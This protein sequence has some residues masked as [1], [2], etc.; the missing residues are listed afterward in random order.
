MRDLLWDLRRLRRGRP[1]G[2][3]DAEEA[4]GGDGRL[5]PGA[6]PVGAVAASGP[7]PERSA[8]RG[9]LARR[10]VVIVWASIGLLVLGA[11]VLWALSR[12]SVVVVPLLVAMFPAAALTPLRNR[13]VRAGW[14]PFLAALTLLLALLAA[15]A[16]L[17]VGPIPA[18][19]AEM[20]ALLRSVSTAIGQLQAYL[21]RLP[22]GVRFGGVDQLVG[23]GTTLLLGADPLAGTVGVAITALTVL[24]GMALCVLSV[25]F[26]LY[27]GDR[28]GRA[29]A[30]LV[31]Q[32]HREDAL[33]L[34]RQ[35][36]LVVGAYVRAQLIIGLL[37]AVFIGIGLWLLGVPLVLPLALLIFVGAQ[38][39]IVGA[40]LAGTVSVLVALADGGLWLAVGALGVIVAVQFTEGHFLE[41]LLMSRLV[42][43]PAFG[44]I[45]SV[46]IGAAAIGVLGALLAVPV[47][48][49]AVRTVQFLRVRR[50]AG[51]APG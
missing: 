32:R 4:G 24:S 39:P 51:G 8:A 35:L 42:R 26:L 33:E 28:I 9:A 3:Q 2:S 47:T 19:V 30:A 31:P 18:I 13:M 17:I 43:L 40:F 10:I 46:A 50:A 25:Y 11:A 37:D 1:P 22:G 38:V 12:V 48:A 15:V 5:P 34:G 23:E 20:P 49:C 21:G 29:I 45:V 36:W 7:S 6:E 27:Q 41:P 16:A 44:V 14:P